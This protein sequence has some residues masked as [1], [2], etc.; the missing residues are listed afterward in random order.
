MPEAR[1]GAA[2]IVSGGL[3]SVSMAGLDPHPMVNIVAGCLGFVLGVFAWCVSRRDMPRGL[4]LGFSLSATTLISCV[5]ASIKRPDDLGTGPILYVW[6]VVHAALFF[7]QRE[8]RITTGW[9]CLVYTAIVAAEL[10]APSAIAAASTTSVGLVAIMLCTYFLRDGID[11]LVAQLSTQA[12]R[13]S[14][15]GLLNRQGLV[16]RLDADTSGSGALLVLDVDHFKHINDRY[17]HSSGD[18]TLAWLGAVLGSQPSGNEDRPAVVARFGG[19][20]FVVWLPGM[21]DAEAAAW[22][23]ALR[24]RVEWESQSR[25]WPVT[26]SIGVGTGR[27][28]DLVGLLNRADHALYQAKDDGRNTVRVAANV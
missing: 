27:T 12:E 3:I 18:A 21:G 15:T 22:A 20:E 16:Q 7:S 2:L 17:G 28:D 14:L 25:L 19:E 24:G 4:F 8:C 1:L 11:D 13:D 6:V 9:C 26:I 10:P 23:D 5:A